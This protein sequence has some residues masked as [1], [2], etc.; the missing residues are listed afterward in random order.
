MNDFMDFHNKLLMRSHNSEFRWHFAYRKFSNNLQNVNPDD[1][2]IATNAIT[3]NM[4][5][6]LMNFGVA[7]RTSKYRIDTNVCAYKRSK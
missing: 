7:I 1:N 5:H 2:Q 6:E 4:A 3:S